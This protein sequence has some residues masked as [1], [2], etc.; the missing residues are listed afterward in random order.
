MQ[1]SSKS[2]LLIKYCYANEDRDRQQVCN[3]NECNT[4]KCIEHDS[5]TTKI[6]KK[7]IYKF[8]NAHTASVHSRKR[9]HE[10]SNSRTFVRLIVL[11]YKNARQS[12]QQSVKI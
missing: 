6:R 10:P 3:E 9:E 8:A 7:G 1:L 11:E 4:N 5:T 12:R 2:L